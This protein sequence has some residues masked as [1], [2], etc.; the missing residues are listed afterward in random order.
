MQFRLSTIFSI[1]FMVAASLAVFCPLGMWFIAIWFDGIIILVALC[2]NHAENSKS[3]VMRGFA[4]IFLGIIC[5]GLLM[6]FYS[7]A[8]PAAFQAACTNNLKQ[9]G[10]ALHN[11][12]D[13][14]SH[15]PAVY[16]CDENGKPLFSWRVEILPFMEY[17]SLYDSLRKDEPWNSPNNSK[18]I[19]QVIPEYLCPGDMNRNYLFT[20]YIAVIGPGTIWR[21]D[22]SVK[23]SDL[24]NGSPRAVVAIEVVNSGVHWA[25]PRELTV[26]QALEGIKTGKGLCISSHH[27]NIINVLFA[28]GTVRALHSGM[29]VSL[30]EKI[31]AGEVEDDIDYEPPSPPEQPNIILCTVIWLF[32]VVLLF[33]R[34]IKSRRKI[35]EAA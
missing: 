10:L 31:F 7:H 22:G 5:P 16:K 27:P 17:G 4:I 1:F 20:N 3:G 14:N 11:Y 2:L 15:F 26:E 34:A 30:W 18:A 9:M 21:K 8:G 25:E 32:S 12:H 24:P 28:D 6:P 33:H 23:L 29:P 13:A 35:I 19:S